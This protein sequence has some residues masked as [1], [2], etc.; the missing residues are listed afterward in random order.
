ML[1]RNLFYLVLLLWF[2]VGFASAARCQGL[3]ETLGKQQVLV[4]SHRAAIEPSVNENSMQS[5]REAHAAGLRMHEIDIRASSDG[6]LFVMHDATMDRTT[7]ATGLI[8]EYPAEVLK[9]VKLKNGRETI[10]TFDDML[11]YARQHDLLLMLDLKGVPVDRVMERV[12]AHDMVSRVLI[13]TFSRETALEAFA[14]KQPV[15]V[16]VLINNMEDYDWY[17]ERSADQSL[18]MAYINQQA[19]M[20]LFMEVAGKGRKIVSDTMGAIDTL[21]REKGGEHYHQ[22]IRE[23]KINIIVSDYPLDV[24][25][26][27]STK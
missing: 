4:C 1:F 10:P 26:A 15:M 12:V 19:D 17:Q 8:S 6:K 27:I 7:L 23:R 20:G 11:R 22:F 18:W 16:S 5:L 3:A 2:T 25:Q 24:M 9:K 13:L 14:L 21:A